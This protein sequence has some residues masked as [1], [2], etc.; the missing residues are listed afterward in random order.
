MSAIDPE[1]LLLSGQIFTHP[2]IYQGFLG[3]MAQRGC[4]LPGERIGILRDYAD[5][6]VLSAGLVVFDGAFGGQP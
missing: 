5:K 1:E 3:R 4:P 6:R 2:A